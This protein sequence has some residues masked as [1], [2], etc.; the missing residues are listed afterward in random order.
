MDLDSRLTHVS[1]IGA[2]GKMGSGIT[3]LLAQEMAR[4]SL[5]PEHRNKSFR[6]DAIDLDGVALRGLRQYLHT[7]ALKATEKAVVGLRA[8]YADR[9]DLV[10]NAEIIDDFLQ[11]VESLVWPSSQLDAARGSTL[12]FEAIVEKIP[13]KVEV[14]RK[15]KET[16]D[17]DAF[18]FTNTSSVPIGLLDRDAG[19]G[20]RIL[21]FHF[22]NPPAVQRL[23]E[24]IR[25]GTTREDAAAAA[26]EIGKRLRKTLIPSSDVAGFIGN[27][28][29][30][31][32]GLHGLSE[33]SRL[34]REHGWPRAAYIV[35]R[36][37]QDWLLR[38][39]GIFQLIDYVGIDVFKFIQ[40]VMDRFLDETLT[41][42]VID[43]MIEQ[44]VLGG[45]N[46]DGSQ[47]P[48][49][50]TYDKGRPT[51]A[52]DPDTRTYVPLESIAAEADR[53][54]GPLPESFRPWKALLDAP[55]KDAA[56]AAHFGRLSGARGLGAELAG[57]YLARSRAIGRGLVASGVAARAED[58]NGV[59][60][61]GFYHL[62]GPIND[63]LA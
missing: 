43:R 50:F 38:P 44:K 58:V 40:D 33:A 61:S 32:D 26:A 36:V 11:R 10:E 30:I 5:L 28:H 12:V 24:V 25:A 41:N 62:Y 49:F 47:K 7:Q 57:A 16:C 22:Y 15:L 2:A 42:P 31:R 21:G 59:L 54:L 52:Y 35:N 17:P 48:G 53:S 34:A 55:D 20:G 19:L 39:M 18:F 56:L 14:F 29:F 51:A 8:L 60:T 13:V 6:L 63:Y 4:L 1:V 37:S 3:L 23:V 27:G 46:P 9:E 45:Q